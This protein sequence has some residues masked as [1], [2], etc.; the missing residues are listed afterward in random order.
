MTEFAAIAIDAVSKSGVAASGILKR[1]QTSTNVTPCSL[2][3]GGKSQS[4][5]CNRPSSAG[6]GTTGSP[7]Q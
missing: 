1:S 3:H 7:S 2:P 4:G 5:S 6:T